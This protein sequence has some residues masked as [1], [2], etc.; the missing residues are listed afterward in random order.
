[1]A[2]GVKPVSDAE[3]KPGEGGAAPVDKEAVA[4]MVKMVAAAVAEKEG[5]GDEDSDIGVDEL[6]WEQLEVARGTFA[7][8]GPAYDSR[9]SAVHE[10]LGD[11]L[12]E[13]DA[14]GARVAA[15]YAAAADAEARAHGAASRSVANCRYMQFLALRR[16][17]PADALTAIAAAI[18]SFRAIA[19]APGATGDDAETVAMLEQ[20][21]G[22][23]RAALD[24]HTRKTAGAAVGT[25]VG[26]AKNAP[27]PPAAAAAGADGEGEVVPVRAGAPPVAVT[28][29]PKRRVKPVAVTPSEGEVQSGVRTAAPPP[30]A[31]AADGDAVE[32]AAKKRKLQQL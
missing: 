5:S 3:A 15:E 14:E 32:P 25:V 20:E 31:I 11:Y 9:L 4:A 17:A 19:A 7:A 27:P 8:L 10:L 28:V 12:S 30:A 6:L 23:Y 16:D 29:V 1:V 13:T 2:G 21:A 24:A 22:A 26:F 18:D